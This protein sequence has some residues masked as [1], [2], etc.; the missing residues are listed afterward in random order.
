MENTLVDLLKQKANLQERIEINEISNDSYCLSPLY[1]L[2]RQQLFD[3]E[4][5]ISELEKAQNS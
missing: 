5:K 1:H 3:L 2:Q 4:Q